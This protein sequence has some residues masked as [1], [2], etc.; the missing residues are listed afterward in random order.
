MI[1]QVLDYIHNYFEKDIVHGTYTIE[2]GSIQVDFLQNGQYFRICGSVFNDGVYEYP[3]NNLTDETFTGE[4]WAMAVPPTVIALSVEI[5]GW[6]DKYGDVM[7]GPYQSESFGGYTYT[8]KSSGG[9][10][11][12]GNDASDWRSVFRSRLNHWRKIS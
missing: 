9:Q 10:S 4:I 7:N 6:V 11:N 8:K 1:E 12:N 3:V 2:S 5:Q